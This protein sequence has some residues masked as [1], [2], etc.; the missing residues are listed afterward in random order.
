MDDLYEIKKILIKILQNVKIT[1]ENQIKL[2]KETQIDD[3]V[4]IKELSCEEMIFLTLP[5]IKAV[6]SNEKAELIKFIE[7]ILKIGIFEIKE[8]NYSTDIPNMCIFN[9]SLKISTNIYN[10]NIFDPRKTFNDILNDRLIRDDK[11]LMNN[12]I[13]GFKVDFIDWEDKD[14]LKEMLEICFY[15]SLLLLR[16]ILNEENMI[17]SQKT[18]TNQEEKRTK[19]F[20]LMPCGH[21]NPVE[22]TRKDLLK[23]RFKPTKTLEEYANELMKELNDKKNKIQPEKKPADS[24]NLRKKDDMNDL[25]INFRGNTK[26]KG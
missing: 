4:N 21:L 13:N 23:N 1:T 9:N 8:D 2:N 16:E 11:I 12:K 26:N 17:S 18:L 5:F 22:L 24:E 14:F 7:S 20:K 19:V 10:Q 15:R 25:T 6:C 3:S